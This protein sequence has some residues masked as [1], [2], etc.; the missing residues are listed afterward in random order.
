MDGASGAFL[1]EAVE[2]ASSIASRG[3]AQS[4]VSLLLLRGDLVTC[5]ATS[6]TP[7]GAVP[8][9]WRVTERP[10]FGEAISSGEITIGPEWVLVPVRSDGVVVGLLMLAGEHRLDDDD[11]HR[12]L[13]LAGLVAFGISQAAMVDDLQQEAE[14]SRGLERLKGEFLNI[15]A[16]ELRSPLGIINGYVSMLLDGTLTGTDQRK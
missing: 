1:R 5:V 6:R 8:G 11:R 7:E 12:W 13:R 2:F 4:E 15:A 9:P 3:D 10:S 14:R 16:H